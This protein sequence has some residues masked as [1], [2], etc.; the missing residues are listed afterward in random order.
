MPRLA[1]LE[2]AR[3]THFSLLDTYY[4]TEALDLRRSGC[5]LRVRQSDGSVLPRLTL[6]GSPEG[7]RE[8]EER[9]AKRTS[10]EPSAAYSAALAGPMSATDDARSTAAADVRGDDKMTTRPEARVRSERPE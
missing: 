8:Q 9:A 10:A 1:D 7:T 3:S 5:S 6:K 4:D 2:L